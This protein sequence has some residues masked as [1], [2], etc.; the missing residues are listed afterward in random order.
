MNQIEQVATLATFGAVW[1]VLVVGHNLADH[2][3]GQSY[4]Q[5]ATKGAQSVAKVADGVSPRRG[6]GACLG[7]VAQYHLVM[8]VVLALAWA[9]LPLQ[10]SWTGLVAG[11]VVSAVTHAFFDR[12][13]PVR[14]LLQHTGSPDFA[15]LET[16]GMNGMYLTDQALHQ[17]ALLV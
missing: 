9:V 10:T 6:W 17:A 7:H 3:F 12:R 16:A 5:A 14:W 15:E 1:A 8:A 4:S 11:L 2:V 13:W